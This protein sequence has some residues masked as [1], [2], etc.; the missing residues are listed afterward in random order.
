M[1]VVGNGSHVDA[2]TEKIGLGYPARDALALSLLALDFE[3][4]DYDTPRVAGAVGVDSG[5]IAI[6]RHDGLIVE[7]T[8]EPM[9]VATYERDTPEVFDL[10]GE[11]VGDAARELY[12]LDFEHPVCAAAATIG[13]TGINMGI[14]NDD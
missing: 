8:D 5:Y 9:L 2:I 12:S 13:D 4:D 6:V 11:T 3:K 7:A 14:Y 1:I 10:R